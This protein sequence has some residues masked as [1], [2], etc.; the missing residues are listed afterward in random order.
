M[1]IASL[2][3]CSSST[4]ISSALEE[5]AKAYA[6]LCDK[7]VYEALD[8]DAV[9]KDGNAITFANDGGITGTDLKALADFT[10]AKLLG[11][12]N[13]L[14]A[15]GFGLYENTPLNFLISD[16]ER[17]LLENATNV[18]NMDY[19]MGY[20]IVMDNDGNL[21][22][23]KGLELITMA[24]TGTAE[25]PSIF[26]KTG[27]TVG[28]HYRKTFMFNSKAVTLGITKD[29]ISEVINANQIYFNASLIKAECKIGA[30]RNANSGVIL[31]KTPVGVNA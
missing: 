8:A 4:Y 21:K 19:K 14:T 13:K 12:K 1:D 17:T 22:R 31:M 26:Y 10:T 27:A 3:S 11:E 28:T 15:K 23:F 29:I 6:Y 16:V 20:G 25:H 18:S 7:V 30:T 5:I 24:S 9:D 2:L